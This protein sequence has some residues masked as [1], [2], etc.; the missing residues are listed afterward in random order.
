MTRIDP[1]RLY[2][3]TDEGAFAFDL[4]DGATRVGSGLDGETVRSF[5]VDPRNPD[6]AFVAC[7]LRGWGLH[8]TRDGGR[9]F[10]RV[11]FEDRWVWDVAL[12]PTD[13]D[14]VYAGT[15]PPTI[16]RSD[17]GGRS[18]TDVPSVDDV[19]SRDRWTFF[20][21]PFEA[22]HLHGIAVDPRDPD[23]VY[24][25]VEH[26]AVVYTHDGGDTWH[27]ALS[28]ADAHDTVVVPADPD[29]VLVS[30]GSG[31]RVTE[32]A[33]ATFEAVGR[34]EGL[35]VKDLQVSPHDPSTVFVDAASGPGADDARVYASHDGGGTWTPLGESPPA[36]VTGSDLLAVHPTD[37]ATLFY[38]T[39]GDGSGVVVSVDGGDT[40][41][42]VGP[43]LP[44]VRAVAAVPRPG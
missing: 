11:G 35:Y 4:G 3:G 18:W 5:A 23:R 22:G 42:R 9:T 16:Q 40:W 2:V 14:V 7:G 25:A 10:E 34:F 21:E 1:C 24:A 27:D 44:H 37:P 41:D 39:H 6:R 33:G 29:R 19:P 15:E 32:D 31:L 12:D 17:D 38:A 13:P 36:S 20:Y 26:G 8:L 43:T 30:T 28:G